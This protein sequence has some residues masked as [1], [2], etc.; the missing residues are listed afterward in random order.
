M[1]ARHYLRGP[2]LQRLAELQVLRFRVIATEAGLKKSIQPLEEALGDLHV[3]KTDDLRLEITSGI[4]STYLRLFRDTRH[5][6]YLDL[7]IKFSREALLETSTQRG[8]LAVRSLEVAVGLAYRRDDRDAAT[9]LSCLERGWNDRN[10]P[11][12]D[13]IMCAT[14]ASRVLCNMSNWNKAFSFLEV[15]TNL[16][17]HIITRS[18]RNTDQLFILSQD[19]VSAGLPSVAA[20]VALELKK[21]PYEALKLLEVGREV[22]AGLS[23]ETRTDLSSLKVQNPKVAQEFLSLRTL[24]DY[25]IGGSV[26]TPIP[27]SPGPGGTPIRKAQASGQRESLDA[28]FTKLLQEIR[29]IPTFERFLLSPSLKECMMAA[30]PGPVVVLNVTE[31]RSDAILV[32]SHQITLLRL[33]DLSFEDCMDKVREI[34][35]GKISMEVLGWL[36]DVAA[37]PILEKLGFLKT[38][39]S[40]VE[41]WPHVWWVLT[42]SLCYL[43]IHAAGYHWN[44]ASNTVLSRVVSSYS[45]SIK[46]PLHNRH[47][48]SRR[49]ELSLSRSRAAARQGQAPP[50]SALLVSMSETS[51]TSRLPHAKIEVE[52]LEAMCQSMSL[53]PI[54]P[55]P[56]RKDVLEQIRTCEIFHLAGHGRTDGET[57]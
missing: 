56:R 6:K 15:A 39:P 10:S 41:T 3:S 13:R 8:F 35:H 34:T 36:W 5:Q 48:K 14:T 32:E 33:K 52:I 19:N 43:P 29:A 50:N 21:T 55:P 30:N 24:L 47:N 9:V 1:P 44:R 25:P 20:S 23:L 16:L 42:G 26:D 54:R 31:Y 38:V 7:A 28:R 18:L 46:A 22:I 11:L 40:T 27:F 17:P 4:G 45:I 37:G 51:G 12:P 53:K 2:V 57:L 49:D